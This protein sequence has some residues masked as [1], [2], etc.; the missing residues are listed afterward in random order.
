MTASAPDTDELLRRTEAQ[1]TPL[2]ETLRLPPPQGTRPEGA[3]C[4]S[5]RG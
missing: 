3:Q 4:L 2:I 5:E 1:L